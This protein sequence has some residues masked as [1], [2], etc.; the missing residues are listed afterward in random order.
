MESK[1]IEIPG[2]C[3]LQLTKLF[4]YVA[5]HVAGFFL[6]YI[7]SHLS[8]YMLKPYS[9]PR[10]TSDTFVSLSLFG[11]SFFLAGTLIFLG[12]QSNFYWKI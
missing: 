1:K 11:S 5:I 9:Q 2:G 10:I 4:T 7:L 8:H 3:S 12:W 6:M